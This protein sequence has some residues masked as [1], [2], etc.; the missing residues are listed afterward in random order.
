MTPAD[1]SSTSAHIWHPYTSMT[2]PLPRIRS[3]GLWRD[4]ASR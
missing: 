1:L 3:I 2:K 4:V